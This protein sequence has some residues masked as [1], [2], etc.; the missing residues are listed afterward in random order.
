MYMLSTVLY[1]AAMHARIERTYIYIT[2]GGEEN[3]RG[4]YIKI[5]IHIRRYGRVYRIMR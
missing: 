2:P 3:A 4:V 1:V 5:P